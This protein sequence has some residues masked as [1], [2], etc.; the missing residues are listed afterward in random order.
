MKKFFF[1]CVILISVL[2]F[3]TSLRERA[4]SA[5]ST[6]CVYPYNASISNPYGY[7]CPPPTAAPFINGMSGIGAY[8]LT[9]SVGI[10]IHLNY[11]NYGNYPYIQS[12]LVALGIRHV[13]DGMQPLETAPWEVNEYNSLGAAGIKAD[14]IVNQYESAGEIVGDILMLNPGVVDA[15][16]NSNELDICCHISNWGPIDNYQQSNLVWPLR[17]IF[18]PRALI[19]G[20]TTGNSS[21]APIGDLSQYEDFGNVHDYEGGFPPENIGYGG[22]SYCGFIYGEIITD[23]CNAKQ[24]SITKPVIATEFGY[25]INPYKQNGSIEAVQGTFIL[26]Q[27]L[28]HE[29]LGVPKS[30]IYELDDS[31]GQTYGLL[32]SDGSQRPSFAEV[33]GFQN[34]LSDT[35]PV[36]NCVVPATVN[37]SGVLSVG[38]CKTTG[39]YDII[40]WQPAISY[41]TN[42][43]IANT[44]APIS[45]PIT[46]NS[47][48]SPSSVTQ[49]TWNGSAWSNVSAAPSVGEA[50]V[51]VSDV[52]TIIS[53]NGPSSPTPLPS[54]P[55]APPTPVPT[56]TPVYVPTPSPAPTSTPTSVAL[57]QSTSATFPSTTVN[58]TQSFGVPV[59]YGDLVLSMWALSQYTAERLVILPPSSFSVID[60]LEVY[61]ATAGGGSTN[62]N[63][64]GLST[65]KGYNT[66]QFGEGPNLNWIVSGGDTGAMGAYDFSGADSLAPIAM[67]SVNQDFF[68]ASTCPSVTVPRPG[69]MVIC[70]IATKQ[71]TESNHGI[72]NPSG[73]SSNWS[74]D[75]NSL[76]S[77]NSFYD[78]HLKSLT[79][80]PNQVIPAF[81][82]TVGT[83]SYGPWVAETIVIQP[84]L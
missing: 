46:F 16:E 15:I 21:Y 36:S 60:P 75:S 84:P 64:I 1:F 78:F 63:E 27:I 32:R 49:W 34:I 14:L 56:A 67:Y 77:Y 25:E 55:T 40:L 43:L 47:G 12:A 23:V 26:R 9:D 70:A 37:T 74:L 17:N 65:W 19:Y 73:F 71:G 41:N 20:P 30:Y 11:G 31:N 54:L 76:G 28:Y 10:N 5:I 66:N 61:P 53:L 79:T 35:A 58:V 8:N 39:E 3:H 38:V 72:L 33:A 18:S 59:A 24:S 68:T 82:V 7:A 48:F 50:T 2:G 69:S 81:N 29:I 83:T 52:P 6:A 80:T 22:G 13:R 4:Q 57:V 51:P 42:T 45:T 62:S 44:I